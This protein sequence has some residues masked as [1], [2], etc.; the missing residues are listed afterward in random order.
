VAR[1]HGDGQ[2]VGGAPGREHRG[3]SFRRS[4]KAG[5][6][7]FYIAGRV[8][9][10]SRVRFVTPKADADVCKIMGDSVAPPSRAGAL[11]RASVPLV[12]QVGH[13][14]GPPGMVARANAGAV[15]AVEVPGLARARSEGKR[16]VR[17][18]IPADLEKAIRAA[19]NKPGRITLWPVARLSPAPHRAQIIDPGRG[20]EA[21][22]QQGGGD[23]VSQ[24]DAA[25]RARPVVGDHDRVD[26]GGTRCLENPNMVTPGLRLARA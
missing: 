14:C 25:D 7:A 20:A 18:P 22:V 26:V 2:R 16:L 13:Q 17:P 5:E 12:D 1:A 24:G 21:R 15:V 19:L 9:S 23:R 4:I 11:S 8:E 10:M 6:G 3:A